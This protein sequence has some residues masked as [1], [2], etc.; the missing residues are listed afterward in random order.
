MKKEFLSFLFSKIEALKHTERKE[1]RVMMKK[2]R[3]EEED[4]EDE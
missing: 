4:D 1:E 3:R 2:R